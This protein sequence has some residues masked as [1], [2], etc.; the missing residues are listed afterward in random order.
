MGSQ[1]R[2]CAFNTQWRMWRMWWMF[3]GNARFAVMLERRRAR[4]E[5]LPQIWPCGAA[6]ECLEDPDANRMP[7]TLGCRYSTLCGNLHG[8]GR[9]KAL[10]VS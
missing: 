9:N 3:A 4:R 10:N 6:L 8:A 2:Q 7:V 5:F 1:Y